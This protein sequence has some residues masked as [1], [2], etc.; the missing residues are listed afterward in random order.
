[1]TKEEKVKLIKET[2]D[3]KNDIFLLLQKLEAKTGIE[4]GVRLGGNLKGL[5][6]NNF[7]SKGK[8]VGMDCWQE[9]PGK[10]EVN[11]KAFSQ[12]QLDQ[13]FAGCVDRFKAYPWIEIIRDFSVEGSKRFEDGF[14]D[15]V[16]L[17]AAHDY[18]SVVD[19]LA[20]WW[21]KVKSGGILSGHD[22]FPD[23]RV[24]RGKEVG[25]WKAVN[26]FAEA[27]NIEVCHMTTENEIEPGRGC[28]SFFIVKD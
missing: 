20:A 19:D 8:L 12:A 11:D 2:C 6:M 18:E 21:P 15:F 24:W 5:S 23:N 28:P 13:Q 26:E 3:L 7:F 16:Y 1:M 10:P 25:V 17:D 4:I 9:V 22:Y 14:F 27:N